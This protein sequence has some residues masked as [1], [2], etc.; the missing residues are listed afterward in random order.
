MDNATDPI[1]RAIRKLVAERHAARVPEL[2]TAIKALETR[3]SALET[4]IAERFK[5]RT[6][7]PRKKKDV[8][9]LSDASLMKDVQTL[10]PFFRK[11][12]QIL[13]AAR[14]EWPKDK[15]RWESALRVEG[16]KDVDIEALLSSRKPKSA[17][18]KVV[19]VKRYITVRAV[20]NALSRSKRSVR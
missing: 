13:R 5:S 6:K 18:A 7:L 2:Q 11:G 1:T 8:S 20:Q 3:N 15:N 4:E 17:A 14:K 12:L 19:A 9:Q 10:E 16:F